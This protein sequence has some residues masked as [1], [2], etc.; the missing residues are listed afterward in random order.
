MSLE[1]PGHY[2]EFRAQDLLLLQGTHGAVPRLQ[3]EV[4]IKVPVW[5]R[6]TFEQPT[7][8]NRKLINR[9]GTLGDVQ[10]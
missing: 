1:I 4:M 8:A 9:R 6:E 3:N 2:T 5:N 10:Q 7:V